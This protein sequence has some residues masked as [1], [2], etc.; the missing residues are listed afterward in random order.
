MAGWINS[1]GTG[2][3]GGRGAGGGGFTNRRY[4][5][6][7]IHGGGGRWRGERSRGRPPPQPHYRYRPVDAAHRHSPPSSGPVL[8]EQAAS[9]TST[10]HA[11]ITHPTST[12]SGIAAPASTKEP[13]DKASRNAAN[14]ECNVCFD[15]A[16]EPVVTKCGHLFCWECLYQWLHVHSHHRE[17]PVCKGQVVDD[18]IIP[19][20]GRG[21]S[22]ASMDNAPPRPTGAR[23]ESSRQQQQH[24]LR[25]FPHP[26]VYMDDQ[27]GDPFDLQGMMNFGFEATSLRDAVMRFMPPNFDDME[28]EDQYDDYS[29]EYDPTDSDEVHDYHLLGFPV[30]AS[31]GA[32]A[33]NPSSSQAHADLSNLTDNIVGTATGVYHHQEFGY[34][35]ANTH[36]RGRHGRR[37]RTR[38][39][40]SADHSSTDGM[41]MGGSGAFYRGNSASSNVSA[42]ASSRP[43]GGWA[44]RRG[45]SS[46]N[47][48]P[49]GGRGVQD[50]RR[51]RPDYN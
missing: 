27:E 44:E 42:G 10:R 45:R 4:T 49:A 15:M 48:N 40:S 2:S 25:T 6:D 7:V 9:S 1:T 8:S 13:D 35:G 37:H 41:L 50:S 3:G 11:Q 14:F 16:A 30:F 5:S 38:A 33:G 24:Q 46:R 26:M 28:M 22:A 51:Q 17:C 39:R 29:Y 34:T 20:Y 31:T 36:N 19:I 21:G 43:N 23:V 47:S 18:A 32:E 12:A